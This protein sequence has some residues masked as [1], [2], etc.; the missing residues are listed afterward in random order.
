MSIT[1]KITL[2]S[3]LL[4]QLFLI[5]NR[6]K[7]K[8]MTMKYASFWIFLIIIMSI[9][10]LFPAIIINLSKLMGFEKTSN[11]I[12]L[13]GFFFLFYTSFIITTSISIQNES[14]NCN[15]SF[16]RTGQYA[17]VSRIVCVFKRKNNINSSYRNFYNNIWC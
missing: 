9:V 1:L 13:I 12:F 8:K 7:R 15:A 2:I 6:V 16:C 5:I 17:S 3:L 11:M 4:L 10:T 14:Y